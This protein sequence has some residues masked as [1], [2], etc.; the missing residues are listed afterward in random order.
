MRG[1]KLMGFALE[2]QKKKGHP[3]H[4]AVEEKKATKEK[5]HC[6]EVTKQNLHCVEKLMGLALEAQK[7]KV[8][9]SIGARKEKKSHEGDSA[10]F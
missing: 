9:P 4:R 8:I 7:K 2:E 10:L 3:K 5:L 6:F 1:E